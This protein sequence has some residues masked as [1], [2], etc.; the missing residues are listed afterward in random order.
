MT[1]RTLL[2]IVGAVG[3]AVAA[4]L[5]MYFVLGLDVAEY[6]I[7]LW[8]VSIPFWGLGFFKPCGMPL[9]Q[10]VPL[11]LKANFTNDRIDYIPSMRLANLIDDKPANYKANKKKE[12]YEKIYKEQCELKGIESYSPRAGR[13]IV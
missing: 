11:W 1:T 6:S 10:F 7:V 4:G 5:Y 3:G 13:V 2:S 8:I 12:K 9:E